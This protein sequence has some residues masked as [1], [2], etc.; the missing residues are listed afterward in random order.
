MGTKTTDSDL[1][2]NPLVNRVLLLDIETTGFKG[3][4]DAI[5]CVV[6]KPFEKRG[7]AY[8]GK[9]KLNPAKKRPKIF[10]V[11]VR[12]PDLLSE[13]RK[14]LLDVKNLIE[15]GG[16]DGGRI[17]GLI[18]YYGTGFDAPMLR[19]RMLYHHIRPIEKIPHLD[20][21]YTVKR[22]VNTASRRMASVNELLRVADTRLEQKT[23]VGMKEWTTAMFTHGPQA[24]KAMRYIKDHC[25]K[26]IY[27]LEE[28]VHYLRSFVPDRILRR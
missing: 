13:E 6:V 9:H 27:V 19:T 28:I 18:T 20:M 21:Y 26:D 23:R 4:F 3:D 8:N 12:N 11:D 15:T 1:F 25:V 14:M 22:V 7:D 2:L 5:L 17:D 24:V 10:S 16:F